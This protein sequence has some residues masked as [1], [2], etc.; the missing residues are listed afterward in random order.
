[1]KDAA[2]VVVDFLYDFIDGSLACLNAETAAQES[3]KFIDK[4]TEGSDTDQVGIH[5]T[6]P[7]LFVCDHHPKDHCSFKPQGGIW[8]P[9][10]VAGTH[11]AE[12]H[13]ALAPHA[14]EEFT[15]YKGEDK[16]TEQYSGFEGVN[17]AGQSLSEVLDLMDIKNVYVCG[18][19]TEF[20]VLN[21][22]KDLKK[23]GYN[24]HLLSSCLGYVDAE[25]HAK[26]I[27]DMKLEGFHVI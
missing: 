6:F 14:K 2:L 19:A 5:D 27:A 26:T 22:C 13:E 1:M 15:F 25:G 23:S 18:I 20:C 9:H 17:E 24:V 3:L 8:P 10:C 12:I 11:G 4:M 7:I 16:T 21:T